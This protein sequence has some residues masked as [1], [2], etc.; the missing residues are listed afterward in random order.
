MRSKSAAGSSGRSPSRNPG[1]FDATE[2][3]RRQG[4]RCLI[5]ADHP[6]A[7]RRIAAGSSLSLSRL[8]ARLRSESEALFNRDLSS[9]NAP[10]AAALMFGG[11]M[12]M[13]E[14]IRDAFAQSG[15][16]HVLAISGTHVAILAVLLLGICRLLGLSLRSTALA[17]IAGVVA[18][19]FLTDCRPPVIRATL[20]VCLFASAPPALSPARR[21]QAGSPW[22]RSRF[23]CGIR[24]TYSTSGPSS[25]FSGSWRSPGPAGQIAGIRRRRSVES[26][27][28][29]SRRPYS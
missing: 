20:L 8:A 5:T 11:R 1:A 28:A 7:V 16:L 26:T 2:F 12:G 15:T 21:W 9:R 25:R 13:D 17:T 18:Y 14:E 3:Y 19:T 22:R 27:L 24:A 10:V 29:A 4:I 23:F 6:D